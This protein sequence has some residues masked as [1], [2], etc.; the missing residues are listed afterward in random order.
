MPDYQAGR[1]WP[2][3]QNNFNSFIFIMKTFVLLLIGTWHES[4]F[5]YF[6]KII[7]SRVF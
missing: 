7:F 3:L 2:A 6:D 5:N 4:T 1:S